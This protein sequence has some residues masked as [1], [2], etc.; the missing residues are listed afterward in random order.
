MVDIDRNLLFGFLAHRLNCLG[1]VPFAKA[2]A[3]SAATGNRSIA[4]QLVETGWLSAAQRRTVEE[5]LDQLLRDNDGDFQKTLEAIAKMAGD[6][7]VAKRAVPGEPTRDSQAV[8]PSQKVSD[9]PH[10][11]EETHDA[12]FSRLGKPCW[13]R[14]RTTT[15]HGCLA[16]GAPIPVHID[17]HSRRGWPG[18]SLAQR[19]IRIC[20]AKSR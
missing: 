16:T 6:T 4:D 2:A 13:G 17:P 10:L 14:T 18:A 15:R 12:P 7:P 19:S 11:F 5:L 9:A 3:G 20:N 8:K 1:T